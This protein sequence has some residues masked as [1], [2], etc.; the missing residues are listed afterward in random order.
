MAIFSQQSSYDLHDGKELEL[1]LSEKKPL[2]FFYEDA[3]MS[4]TASQVPEVDFDPF[5][6]EGRLCKG[7]VVVEGAIDPRTARPVRTRYVLYAVREEQ[8]R[9][10]AMILVWRTMLRTKKRP[11]EG[12]DRL[13]GSLLGYTDEQ[14]DE[15][16]STGTNY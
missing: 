11:D 1:M 4:P 13:T 16:I 8:W 15:Y 14:N 6:E 10:P 3:D 7:E 2:A 9:I 5:V 12:L